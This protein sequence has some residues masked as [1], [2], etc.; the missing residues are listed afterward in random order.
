MAT[1]TGT[2]TKKGFNI[3]EIMIVIM[4]IGVLAAASFGAFKWLQ[5]AKVTTTNTKL[6]AVDTLLENYNTQLGEYPSV[7]EELIAGPTK[8]NL[9]K[10]WGAGVGADQSDLT[11]AW[12]QTFVYV[13]AGPRYTLY[14]I[15]PKG[16]QQLHSP[17]S[18]QG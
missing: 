16:D 11:D 15:G 10:K 7:L 6:A 18:Q 5:R 4:I 8:P 1:H 2:H 17:R 3:I 9:Q 13:P 12:N 14:S